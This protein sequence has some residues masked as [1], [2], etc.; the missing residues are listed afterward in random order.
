MCMP[1]CVRMHACMHVYVEGSEQEALHQLYFDLWVMGGSQ[2][3]EGPTTSSQ[4]VAGGK[5]VKWARRH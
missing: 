1:V 4:E 2:R 5:R 3:Q